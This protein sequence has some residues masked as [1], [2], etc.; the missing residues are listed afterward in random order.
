MNKLQSF[1]IT[2]VCNSGSNRAKP[3]DWDK[4]HFIM[5]DGI[6]QPYSTTLPVRILKL[7]K[8]TMRAANSHPQISRATFLWVESNSTFY[9]LNS[10]LLHWISPAFDSLSS[11]YH[12][13]GTAFI[14]GACFFGVGEQ[15]LL[16]FI[17]LKSVAL[18]AESPSKI[19]SVYPFTWD[20]WACWG[21]GNSISDATEHLHRGS[22]KVKE[23][24]DHVSSELECRWLGVR[25]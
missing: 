11:V 9:Q 10:H 2:C 21:H 14:C 6:A 23:N 19:R 12:W 3:M 18:T 1:I 8:Q 13:I 4:Q 7:K 15:L 24:R 5:R 22:Q 17:T 16:H 25:L 20:C